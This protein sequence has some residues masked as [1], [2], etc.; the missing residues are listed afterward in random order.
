[1]DKFVPL[2]AES[3]RSQVVDFEAI[4]EVELPEDSVRVVINV[5]KDR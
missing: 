1:M 3:I 5:R 4:H 2:I